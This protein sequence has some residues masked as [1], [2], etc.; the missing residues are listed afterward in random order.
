LYL[1]TEMSREDHW[2]KTVAKMAQVDV[3]LVE[4]GKFKYDERKK[5]RVLKAIDVIENAP[6][7]LCPIAGQPF[8][9]TLA[10]MHRWVKTEVGMDKNGRLKDCLVIFDYL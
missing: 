7:H 1:D 9:E 2:N 5:A 6:F 3:S 4:T 8:E 10:T